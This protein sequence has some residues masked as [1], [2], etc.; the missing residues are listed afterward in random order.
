MNTGAHPFMPTL[1]LFLILTHTLSLS[2][3][4]PLAALLSPSPTA[5][6]RPFEQW[7]PN[8]LQL[9][10]TN[11][12]SLSHTHTHTLSLSPPSPLAA[13]LSPSPTAAA[14]PFGQWEP[15]PRPQ[16][17]L[18]PLLGGIRAA[19]HRSSEHPG[20]PTNK[21]LRIGCG[22]GFV[23]CGCEFVEPRAKRKER[24]GAPSERET[25]T[26]ACGVG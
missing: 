25:G 4:S 3:P 11:K 13:L 14:R 1:F 9:T 18:L 2:P 12:H 17:R 24:W 15:R 6:A 5:A 19:P 10:H 21:G 8:P 20:G 23:V 7:E 16:P 22:R 26:A